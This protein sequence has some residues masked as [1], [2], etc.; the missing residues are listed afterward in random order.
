MQLFPGPVSSGK[1]NA[2]ALMQVVTLRK[3]REFHL[4][5]TLHGSSLCLQFPTGF[6]PIMN[7]GKKCIN[8]VFFSLRLGYS[9]KICCVTALQ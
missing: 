2:E 8:H 6:S 9:Y 7:S 1:T 5:P 3:D 4:L